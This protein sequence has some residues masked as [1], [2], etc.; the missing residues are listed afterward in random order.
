MEKLAKL[1]VIL[2]GAI[3]TL[4]V[5]AVP[6]FSYNDNGEDLPAVAAR[7]YAKA[8]WPDE[9]S[10]FWVS[11][12]TPPSFG[13]DALPADASFHFAFTDSAE[14]KVEI[15]RAMFPGDYQYISAEHEF[16]MNYLH[17]VKA[18]AVADLKLIVEGALDAPGDPIEYWSVGI[19]ERENRTA[20]GVPD[21]TPEFKAWA[22]DRW[23]PAAE[24]TTQGPVYPAIGPPLDPP[25]P[26]DDGLTDPGGPGAIG[27]KPGLKKRKE[28]L[29]KCNRAARSKSVA[30][31]HFSKSKKCK[32]ARRGAKVWQR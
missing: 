9:Y 3:L 31:K 18:L 15:L 28:L 29:K 21:A 19:G 23:G 25:R 14:A 17:E 7:D 16:S 24:V 20:V 32:R 1:A 2:L 6:A 13:G 5:T 27:P 11:Y 12:V 26:S 10:G 8:Q 22:L 4:S 30:R